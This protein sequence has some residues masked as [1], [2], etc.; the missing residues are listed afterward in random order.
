MSKKNPAALQMAG[1][2]MALVLCDMPGEG[3]L[4]GHLVQAAPDLITALKG[5]GIVDDHEAAVAYAMTQ[6]AKVQRP[7]SELRAEAEAAA[8]Q[9]AAEAAPPGA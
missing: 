7:F 9:A 4:A 8:A 2:A 3:L 1:L 6:Q 5:Q